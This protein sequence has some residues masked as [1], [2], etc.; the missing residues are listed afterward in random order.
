MHSFHIFHHIHPRRVVLLLPEGCGCSI[1]VV[2]VVAL[3]PVGVEVWMAAV[4]R[5]EAVVPPTDTA[6]EPEPETRTAPPESSTI[7]WTPGVC[8]AV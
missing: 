8:C 2:V 4:A 7:H 5:L 3:D 6:A 1:N